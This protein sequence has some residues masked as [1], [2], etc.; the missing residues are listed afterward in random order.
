MTL[1]APHMTTIEQMDVCNRDYWDQEIVKFKTVHPL[2][3]YGWGK[4]R[5]IDGWTAI[6]LMAKKDGV[7]TGA[8]MVLTKSIPLTPFSIMYIPRGPVF[9]L[10]DRETLKALLVK[11]RSE[12]RQKNAIFL[13]IDPNTPENDISGKVDPFV[14]EGFIH[15]G[16]RWTDWNAPKDVFRTDLTKG[17]TEEQLFQLIHPKARSGVRKARKEGIAIRQAKTDD[18][19]REFYRVFKEFAIGKGFLYRGF[20]YQQAIWEEFVKR[21]LG[22][23]FL[24]GHDE[25]IVGGMLC[26]TFGKICLEMHRGVF[27]QYQKLRVNEALVWEGIRWAKEN[28]CDWYCQRGIGS[29]ALRKFKEKFNPDLV[30]LAGYYDLVYSPLLYAVFNKI[31]FG[32]IPKL[33]PG[34]KKI[35]K[36]YMA[37]LGRLGINRPQSR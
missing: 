15:L 26:L 27:S 21:K 37:C 29:L 11:I 22:V 13:R 35:R 3:A 32:L 6:C 17:E 18:E 28:Q 8:A 16:N 5:A 23:L 2:N 4:V 9:D 31:E 20:D 12:A 1:S 25:N 36:V 19:V 7:V 24:S 30:S 14:N 10:S 33:L 34:L